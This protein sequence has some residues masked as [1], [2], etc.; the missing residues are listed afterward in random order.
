MLLRFTEDAFALHL[1][2]QDAERLVDIVV[3][4]EYL[5]EISPSCGARMTLAFHRSVVTCRS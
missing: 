4:N 2:L 1:L 5:Q 3:S